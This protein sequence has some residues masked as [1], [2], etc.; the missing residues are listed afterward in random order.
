MAYQSAPPRHAASDAGRGP[1]AVPFT[2]LSDRDPIL[3][4][5]LMHAVERVAS[6]GNFTLGEEVE[7][8]ERE[9]AAYCGADH[10][11]GVASG[12]EALAL[13]LRA[14]GVGP[15]HEVIVPSNSF[16]ATAEAVVLAGATPRL[17]DVDPISHTL[18][19]EIVQRSLSERTRCVVPVHLYGRTADLDPIVELARANGL[20]VLE[21]ACQAHGASYGGRRVGTIGDAGCFSFY[22]AKNLGAWGDGGAVVTSDESL[23]D[24]VRLLRS[25]GERVKHRHE[26]CGT[27]GRLDAIQAAVL[28]V[29]LLHLD[30]W[31]AR[32]RQVAE[33]L[34]DALE[35]SIVTPPA[36]CPPSLDHVFHLYVVE[37]EQRSAVCDLLEAQGVA[38]GVHYPVPNHL[39]EAFAFLGMTSGSLPVCERLADRVLSLPIFPSM[40]DQ[41]VDHVASVLRGDPATIQPSLART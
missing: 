19:A 14:L 11:V 35:G 21:D 39:Q 29:K 13:S 17:V 26:V 20:T 23:A 30:D 38:T 16:I 18:T 41:A 31:T 36:P 9:F 27:T 10:A 15:G 6:Q 8:F 32:R 3:H 33:K 22:P 4:G 28:R 37:C 2:E 24:R 34:T 12:T 5:E 40:D 1:S 7:A 25:H